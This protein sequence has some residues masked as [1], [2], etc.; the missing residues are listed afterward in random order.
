MEQST[1]YGKAQR[2]YYETH[3]DTINE[4]RRDYNRQYAAT[5]YEK[6]KEELNAARRKGTPRGRPRKTTKTND[7]SP[8]INVVVSQ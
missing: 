7:S 1:T 5:Y 8:E 4:R 3:K 2:K 6:H